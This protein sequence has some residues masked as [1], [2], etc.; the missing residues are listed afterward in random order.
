MGTVD[1]ESFPDAAMLA[2]D[3]APQPRTRSEMHPR[4]RVPTGTKAI[5]GLAT[6]RPDVDTSRAGPI[7]HQPCEGR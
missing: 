4:T 2:I 5:P 3:D 7:G 1:P 6:L